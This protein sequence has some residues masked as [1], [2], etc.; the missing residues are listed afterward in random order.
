MFWDNL[1]AELDNRNISLKELAAKAG[2]QQQS[3]YNA[4]T[5]HT[6]PNLDTACKIAK[7]LK[8]SVEELYTGNN[9]SGL[10]DEELAVIIRFRRLSKENKAA[11]KQLLAALPSEN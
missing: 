5:R 8:M 4:I 6:L 2:L 11:I 9:Y 3:I 1:K 10:N 7:A